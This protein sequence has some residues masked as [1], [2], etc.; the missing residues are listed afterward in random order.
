MGKEKK[1]KKITMLISLFFFFKALITEAQ[2]ELQLNISKLLLESGYK[3][4][5]VYRGNKVKVFF[6]F[7]YFFSVIFF[8]PAP[9]WLR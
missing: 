8:S 5:L 9:A 7:V 1:K 2:M 3:L 6:L 4:V